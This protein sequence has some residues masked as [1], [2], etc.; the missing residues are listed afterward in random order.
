MVQQYQGVT[1]SR[2]CSFP[3]RS[4]FMPFIDLFWHGLRRL[5]PFQLCKHHWVWVW[6]FQSDV[7]MFNML[8]FRFVAVTKEACLWHE[9][10]RICT[11]WCHSVESA[12]CYKIAII[13]LVYTPAHFNK[14]CDIGKKYTVMFN[15]HDC[16]RDFKYCFTTRIIRTSSWRLSPKTKDIYNLTMLYF[17]FLQ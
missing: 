2:W 13:P 9:T 12:I 10:C 3:S 17:C 15:E 7:Y 1:L 6:D 16:Q 4:K 11:S 5:C 14:Q 8:D